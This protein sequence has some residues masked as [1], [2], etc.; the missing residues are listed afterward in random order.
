MPFW[1]PSSSCG[2]FLFSYHW[3]LM[4]NDLLASFLLLWWFLFHFS[5]K[6]DAKCSSGCSLPLLVFSHSIWCQM[7]F[8]L[9]SSSC[10][11]FLF[12]SYWKLM[13]NTLLTGLLLLWWFLIQFL[14][15]ADTKYSVGC[16]PSPSGGHP[17]P[18]VVPYSV[19]SESW[20]QMLFWRP[21]SNCGGILLNSWWKLI[22]NTLLA[23]LLFLWWFLSN[24]EWKLIPNTLLAALLLLL[25]SIL[26]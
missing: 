22:P 20:Y 9:S 11:G 6:T 10:G 19:L 21:S 24:S 7:L 4:S 13:P 16:P 23:A 18:V 8:W 1:L 17:P 25:V 15:K 5:F 12:N 14:V 2:S 26:L 3:K